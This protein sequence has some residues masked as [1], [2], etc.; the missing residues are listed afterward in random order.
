MR[1]VALSAGKAVGNSQIFIPIAHRFAMR[2]TL[3]VTVRGPM[4]FRA[5]LLGLVE[6]NQC[7]ITQHQLVA[8][9]QIVAII[10]TRIDS[11]I[12]RPLDFVVLKHGEW[13]LGPGLE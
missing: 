8:R 6:S 5:N 10:A 1:I 13:S 9:L 12:H 7:F 4:A 2:T 11:M 3:P